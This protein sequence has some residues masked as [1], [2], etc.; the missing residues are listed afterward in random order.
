MSA[1]ADG[2]TL[3]GLLEQLGGGEGTLR[4]ERLVVLLA[5]AAR[6]LKRADDEGDGCQLG[7]GVADLIL[8]QRERLEDRE[9]ERLQD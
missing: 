2:A 3:V 7:L 9:R 4:A 6:P 8:V 1:D 5:E